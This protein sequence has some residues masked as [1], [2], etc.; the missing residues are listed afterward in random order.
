M[1]PDRV[2]LAFG[3]AL[4]LVGVA[5]GIWFTERL[6]EYPGPPLV[7]AMGHFDNETGDPALDG[8]LELVLDEGRFVL[9]DE[10]DYA[11]D[12]GVAPEGSGYHVEARV[13]ELESG[14]VLAVADVTVSSKETIP[15]AFEELSAE[16][17][18]ELART[19]R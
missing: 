10:A 9:G 7:V 16:L 6:R 12:G 4:L 5:S 2:K 13:L 18:R 17:R 1:I 11:L 19:G 3:G 8:T 14:D 15:R